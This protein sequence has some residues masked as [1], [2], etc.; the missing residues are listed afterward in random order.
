MKTLIVVP[1]FNCEPVIEKV[2]SDL[3]A[4]CDLPILVVDDGSTKAVESIVSLSDQRL[5]FLR[6]EKNQGKGVALQ[7]AFKFGLEKGY[8]HILSFDGDGQHV[9]SEVPSLIEKSQENPND[10]VIGA[11]KFKEGVPGI[12]QFGRK[13]SNFWVYYQS[14]QK[15]SDSQSG[16]RVYPLE[17][18]SSFRFFTKRYDF[19]IEVLVR[20]LWSGVAV[21]DVPV[22]VIYP[23]ERI[24][25]F[26]KF[27]D[28]ARITGLNI[29]LIAYSLIF[30]QKSLLKIIFAGLFGSVLS[31]LESAP[32]SLFLTVALSVIFRI[33]FVL[34]LIVLLALWTYD[35]QM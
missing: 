12:S 14:G 18:L 5:T 21:T 4:A 34:M 7:Q 19:E 9:A 20:A 28:N 24:S 1:V 35:L 11:R 16:M 30:Y 32:L 8:T 29:L 22:E 10:I 25:H 2:I 33:N 15:V 26:N 31:R 3:L 27:R 17:P 13:F 6:F 23:K